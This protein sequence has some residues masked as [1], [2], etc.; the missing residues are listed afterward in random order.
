MVLVL[1][2][3]SGCAYRLAP[4]PRLPEG[5]TLQFDANHGELVTLQGELHREVVRELR[6]RFAWRSTPDGAVLYLSIDPEVID[7]AARGELGVPTRWSLGIRGSWRLESQ[8]HGS[9]SGRFDATGHA[10]RREQ[11]QAALAT[12]A[13]SAA[14]AIAGDIEQRMRAATR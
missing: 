2:A 12:A 7:V 3:L 1:L 6:E 4:P 5:F 10:S 14:R 13:A 11:E 8:T 9:L